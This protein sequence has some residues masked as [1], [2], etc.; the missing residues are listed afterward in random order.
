MTWWLEWCN[1]VALG[2]H[3][4]REG[5][6]ASVK[7]CET[8][9]DYWTFDLAYDLDDRVDGVCE[10]EVQKLNEVLEKVLLTI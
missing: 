1:T 4:H 8:A 6:A 2:T 9:A 3:Y 5:K 7:N 10:V